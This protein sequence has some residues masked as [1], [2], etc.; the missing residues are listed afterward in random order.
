MKKITNALLNSSLGKRLAKDNASARLT[1]R[2][3]LASAVTKD[4]V[5]CLFYTYQSLNNKRIPEDQRK[6]V[7]A[8]D[9][10]NGILNVGVQVLMAFGV[11]DAIMRLFD[12]KLAPKYFSEEESAIQKSYKKLPEKLAKETNYENFQ[13]EFIELTRRKRGLAKIGFQ[14]IAVSVLLQIVTK[15]MITP[16]LATPAA[17]FLKKGMEKH[18]AEQAMRKEKLAMM[19]NATEAKETELKELANA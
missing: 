18:D 7:G 16:F 1:S 5:G 12:K 11:E 14:A 19:N 3:V 4:A 10:A 2:I 9:F 8:L 17:S 6:F 13:K 15:R